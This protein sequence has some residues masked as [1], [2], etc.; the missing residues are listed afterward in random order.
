MQIKHRYDNSYTEQI[1]MYIC[2][3]ARTNYNEFSILL[4]TDHEGTDT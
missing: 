3:Y 2:S 1:Y 4:K